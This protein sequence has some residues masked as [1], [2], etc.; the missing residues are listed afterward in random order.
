VDVDLRSGTFSTSSKALIDTGAP[1][2]VFPRGFARLLGITLPDSISKTTGK[3]TFLGSEWHSV[4]HEIELR[5]RP[6][7]EITWIADIDFVVEDELPFALLGHEG[8]LNRWSVTFNAGLGYF[9]IEDLD[10]AHAR[11]EQDAIAD[12]KSRHPQLFPPDW[13]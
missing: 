5:I 6:Y 13:N 12:M 11:L 1:R 7:S 10:S 8:F 4:T 3:H 2:C 9:T